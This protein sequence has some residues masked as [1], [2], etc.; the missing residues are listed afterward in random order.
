MVTLLLR[1]LLVFLF[2]VAIASAQACLEDALPIGEK[3]LLDV[4]GHW[5]DVEVLDGEAKRVVLDQLDFVDSAGALLEDFQVTMI[6]SC[7]LF[8]ND[9]EGVSVRL[10]HLMA[11]DNNAEENVDISAYVVTSRGEKFISQNL[12]AQLQTSCSET[13]LRGCFFGDDGSIEVQ[14]LTHHFDCETLKF[15]E[16]KHLPTRHVTM[17]DDGRFLIL[18][19]KQGGVKSD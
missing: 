16:S 13:Y 2:S 8:E 7:Q 4:E 17:Q 18:T 10:Y 15:K 3:E 14:Q 12:I 11:G 9:P 1:S 6:A 5:S 19:E